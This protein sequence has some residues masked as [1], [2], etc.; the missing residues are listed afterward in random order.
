V[1]SP[2]PQPV[3]P[4][5]AGRFPAASAP[6]PAGAGNAHKLIFEECGFD[7][8]PPHINRDLLFNVSYDLADRAIKLYILDQTRKFLY[9]I[10]QNRS[11]TKQFNALSQ[12]ADPTRL[13]AFLGGK[14]NYG[15]ILL[16]TVEDDV[17]YVYIEHTTPSEYIK[18]LNYLSMKFGVSKPRLVEVANRINRR[19]VDSIFECCLKRSISGIKIPFTSD[20]LKLYAR[21]YL[22]GTGY[23]LPDHAAEFLARLY[24]CDVAKLEPHLRHMWVSS[25]VTTD[26][27]V[28][29]TQ[30]E[31]LHPT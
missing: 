12:S 4:A 11:I 2:D 29:T 7:W 24:N 15:D 17:Y 23:D 25:E 20:K 9:K 22:M 16:D 18:L 5:D 30:D 10:D 1:S 27:I 19:Q 28:L 14:F 31:S 26:R 21:P 6:H 3:A 8:V 13:S